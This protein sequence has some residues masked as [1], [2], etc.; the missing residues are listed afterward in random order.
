MVFRTLKKESTKLK[1]SKALE[2]DDDEQVLTAKKS[3]QSSADRKNDKVDEPT[4]VQK[5]ATEKYTVKAGETLT[6][7]AARSGMSVSEFAE[8]NNLKPNTSLRSGQK[9]QM[10]KRHTS[11]T[12]KSGDSLIRLAKKYG[13][14]PQQFAEL[15]DLKPTDDLQLGKTIKVPSEL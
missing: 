8:L 3:D 15:N 10:V 12:V 4:K 13:M 14:T 9:L 5:T 1:K 11:Y 7:L 6:A 2:Q